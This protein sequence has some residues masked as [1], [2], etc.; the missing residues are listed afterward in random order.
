[1][2]GT[3]A[4]AHTARFVAGLVRRWRRHGHPLRGRPTRQLEGRRPVQT[5]PGRLVIADP[6]GIRGFQP[7]FNEERQFCQSPD[8]VGDGVRTAALYQT[9]MTGPAIEWH[10]PGVTSRI[11]D[12]RSLRAV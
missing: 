3:P 4:G 5:R 9:H 12:S 1:M 10:R 7:G 6:A 11:E 8:L 2:V